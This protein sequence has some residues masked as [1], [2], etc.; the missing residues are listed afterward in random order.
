MLIYSNSYSFCI[1]SILV[2]KI[3]MTLRRKPQER[4]RC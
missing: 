3:T 2:A 4:A 1:A